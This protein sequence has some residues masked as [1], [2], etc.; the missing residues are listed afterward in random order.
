[1]RTIQ[2]ELSKTHH[3]TYQFRYVWENW[4]RNQ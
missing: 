1:M 4:E 2:R 3:L